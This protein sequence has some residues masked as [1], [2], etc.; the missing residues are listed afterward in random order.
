MELLIQ[1]AV[2]GLLAVLLASLLKRYSR[3]MA[4]LLSLAACVFLALLLL[5]IARPVVEFMK[6][7]RNLAGLDKS[8]M[9]PL[10]KTLGIALLT[11]ICATICAD[12]GEHAIGNLIEACGGLLAVYVSIPLLEAVL[13]MV[14]SMVGGG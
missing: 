6:R 7:L 11:Q 10:L 8:L 4:L 3:E 14:E 5:Q 13:D 1:A 12:A 2:L 9:E